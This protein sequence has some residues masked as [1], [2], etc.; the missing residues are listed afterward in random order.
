MTDGPLER[1]SIS[2]GGR[3]IEGFS[4]VSISVSIEEAAR[5]ASVVI[6]D[7]EGADKVMPGDEAVIT[8]SG[9][10]MLT[11]YVGT[12]S[13]QHDAAMHSVTIEI[14]S[15]TIDAV[16]ASIVHDSGFVT[17]KDLVAIANEFD[18]CGVGIECDESFPVEPRSFVNLGAS[19]HE[20]LV[21]IARSH[22]AFIYDTAEGK[23]RLAKKP[24]GRHSGA[25]RIGTGGNILAASAQI[26]EHGRHDEII[27]RGQSSRGKSAVALRIE[28]IAKDS[29]VKR[30]RPKVVVH[31]SEATS[32]KLKE[33]ATRVVRRSAGYSRT[34]TIT[35]SGWRDA[36]GAIFE[37]HY[38]IAVEDPRI[39]I[40]QDMGIKSVTFTQDTRAGG[41]GTRAQISLVDPPALN[42]EAAGGAAQ[43]ETPDSDPEIEAE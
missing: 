8:A 16:E 18:T 29:G 7:F 33:R 40:S 9:T 38:L 32:G 3:K 20:H 19:L 31:E 5:K 15:R 13:P 1:V 27:V 12:V 22:G 23:L 43:W 42:G 28:A 34:A 36:G 21:P 30:R 2:I 6:A 25:L 10:T 26:S 35:V 39:Y 37:P 17:D 14:A 11:G 41:P 24:R 4:T